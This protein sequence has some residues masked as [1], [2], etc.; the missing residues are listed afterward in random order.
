MNATGV[1]FPLRLDSL[2]NAARPRTRE[3]AA[4]ALIEEL[5]FTGL[6]ERLNRPDLGCGLL[7]MVFDPS[8]DELRAATQ[9]QVT[10]E[11]QRWLSD[12][13]RVI[14]LVVDSSGSQLTVTVTYAMVSGGATGTAVFVR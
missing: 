11:L 2:G 3:A 4:V 10:S 12:V 9:F 13:I 5:L 14:S 8:T 1:A 7:E 6:G